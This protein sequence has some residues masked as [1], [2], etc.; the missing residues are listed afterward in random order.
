MSDRP[1][2]LSPGRAR[3]SSPTLAEGVAGF[4]IVGLILAAVAG[5]IS[6]LALFRLVLCLAVLP[7][8]VWIFSNY[9]AT[10]PYLQGFAFADLSTV[11]A[12]LF[13]LSAYFP[14][15]NVSATANS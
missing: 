11:G 3:K 15:A 5:L 14:R 7:G 12:I 13:A 4:G 8:I 10:S 6:A 1:F 9:V 2:L